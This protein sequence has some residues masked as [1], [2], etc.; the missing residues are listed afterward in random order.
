[1]VEGNAMVKNLYVEW[2]EVNTFGGKAELVKVLEDQVAT[3]EKAK[4]DTKS[5]QDIVVQV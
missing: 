3:T 4:A 1:M 5:I 2:C